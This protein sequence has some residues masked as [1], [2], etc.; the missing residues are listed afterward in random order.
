MIDVGQSDRRGRRVTLR[1]IRDDWRAVAAHWIGRLVI[2]A[3]QQGLGLGRASM[4]TLMEWLLS[5]PACDVVGLSYHPDNAAAAQMYADLGFAPTAEVEDGEI[6]VVYPPRTDRPGR[7]DRS[8]AVTAFNACINAR[9]LRGL[10]ALMAPDHAFVD[11]SGAALHGRD[12]AVAAWRRFFEHF[13]DYRNVFDEVDVRDDV[14]VVTGRSEC[15]VEALD[16]PALWT[17]RVR[18]G[19]V[20]EWRVYDDT[21]GHRAAL[22]L[23]D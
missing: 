12:A 8:D 4:V 3:P 21:P 13:P 5:K 7:D 15:P 11:A 20:S 6:V 10:T 16:G 22:G 19:L 1:Q 2:D 14:V 17:A 18:D 23:R 9:D